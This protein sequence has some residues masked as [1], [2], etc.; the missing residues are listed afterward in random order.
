[1]AILKWITLDVYALF[2]SSFRMLIPTPSMEIT[3][4]NGEF[5]LLGAGLGSNSVKQEM[6]LMA[7]ALEVQL[8]NIY[9]KLVKV[10]NN[11][12]TIFFC[13]QCTCFLTMEGSFSTGG[14]KVSWLPK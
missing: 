10:L 1:M 14:V 9:T 8:F 11:N 4:R 5:V 7:M 12:H 13:S 2:Y 6:F 3:T